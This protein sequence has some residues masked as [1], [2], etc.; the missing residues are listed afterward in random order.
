MDLCNKE[1]SMVLQRLRQGK[2]IP[3]WFIYEL[4]SLFGYL[5]KIFCTLP[6]QLRVET[7][8]FSWSSSIWITDL[9]FTVSLKNR[10]VIYELIRCTKG[11][12]QPIHIINGRVT[13]Y[14][15]LIINLRNSSF[16]NTKYKSNLFRSQ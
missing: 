11:L 6:I 1:K 8:S 13:V 15:F 16:I 5:I 12:C 3:V 2:Y 9:K 14:I 4:T 7:F 10:D